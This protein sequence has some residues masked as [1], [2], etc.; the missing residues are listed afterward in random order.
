MAHTFHGLYVLHYTL[1]PEVRLVFF[2][3]LNYN[4]CL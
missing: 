3:N 2:Q 1:A 4:A